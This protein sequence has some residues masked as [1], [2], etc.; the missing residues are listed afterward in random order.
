MELI[1]MIAKEGTTDEHR[2]TQMCRAA[3]RSVGDPP[4]LEA[5]PAEIKQQAEPEARCLQI[6]DALRRMDAVQCFHRLELNH[7][8]ALDQ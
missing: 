3:R 2:C 8:L 7:D 4:D 5:R 6:I 1:D